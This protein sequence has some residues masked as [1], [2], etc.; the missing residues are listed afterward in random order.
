MAKKKKKLFKKGLFK[1]AKEKTVYAPLIAYRPVMRA[2]LKK[3][4]GI[5]TSRKIKTKELAALFYKHVLKRSF[6]LKEYQHYDLSG[7]PVNLAHLE[8]AVDPATAQIAAQAAPE[9]I[10][11]IVDFIKDFLKRNKN[12]IEDE[13]KKAEKEE[14][15]SKREKKEEKEKAG[16]SLSPLVIGGIAAAVISILLIFAFKK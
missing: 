12:E 6:E 2:I 13:L 10:K 16:I 8:H 5:S 11:V 15:E 9:L 4:A 14:E 1:K 3:K 7:E